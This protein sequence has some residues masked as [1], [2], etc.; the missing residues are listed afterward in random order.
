[1]R[2]GQGEFGF[3]DVHPTIQGAVVKTVAYSGSVEMFSDTPPERTAEQEETISRALAA[4][5]AG[6]RHF[7]RSSPHG[8]LVSVR[9]RVFGDT[10]DDL[11]RG[12]R[13]GPEERELV[14]DLLRRLAAAG[15]KPA[16]LRAPNVMIGRTLLDP[17]RRAYVVDGGKFLPVPPELDAEGRY[18]DLLNEPIVIMARFDRYAGMIQTTQTMREVLD[19]GVERSER[20]TGW[21]RFKGFWKDLPRLF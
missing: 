21:Q 16:D 10:L 13:L 15:L 4:A 8:Y 12:R 11:S 1:V 18:R 19:K 17:R 6:P 3:V 20:V 7:G 5:D 2:L 9:E 14:L